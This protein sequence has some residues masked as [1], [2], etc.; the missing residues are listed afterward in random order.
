MLALV[1]A[2]AP[3]VIVL[4][5]ILQQPVPPRWF[6]WPW[7]LVPVVI[8]LV[9]HKA[10]IRGWGAVLLALYAL[11]PLSFSIGVLYLPAVIALSFAAVKSL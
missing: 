4:P 6:L 7:L 9:A 1:L 2:I 5:T 10:N 8:V 11:C 3:L